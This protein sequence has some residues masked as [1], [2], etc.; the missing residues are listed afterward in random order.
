MK[1]VSFFAKR[2]K[3][4]LRKNTVQKYETAQNCPFPTHWIFQS[5]PPQSLVQTDTNKAC[6]RKIR[7]TMYSLETPGARLKKNWGKNCSISKMSSFEAETYFYLRY[8]L[9]NRYSK[10]FINKTK[11]KRMEKIMFQY[12]SSFC[13]THLLLCLQLFKNNN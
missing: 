11:Q 7:E 8:R 3:T 6:R 12:V 9:L 2:P 1:L 4:S 10:D 13:L 5:F